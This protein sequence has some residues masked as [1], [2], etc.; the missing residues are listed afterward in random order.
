MS[1][2]DAAVWAYQ[3][4]QLTDAEIEEIE[5]ARE[6]DYQAN[7]IDYTKNWLENYEFEADS[8]LFDTVAIWHPSFE[9]ELFDYFLRNPSEVREISPRSFEKLV[10][11]IFRNQGF[12]VELT[13]QAK[14]GGFDLLAIQHSSYT[15]SSHYLVECKRYA[16][17]NKVGV[18]IV[19]SLY[20]VVADRN[21][22]KGLVVT[23]S[24]FTSGAR[25]FADRNQRRLSLADYEVLLGWLENIK[26]ECAPKQITNG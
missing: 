14:D 4:T 20:G 8:R 9:E 24:F 13:P 17:A 15:G 18:D 1:V 16:E 2:F 10:A 11:S 19:R 26:L 22:T 25:G 7:R 5:T 12:D 21:A 6:A 3:K 23:T